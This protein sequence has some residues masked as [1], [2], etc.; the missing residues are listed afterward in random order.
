MTVMLQTLVNQNYH[1]LS[2][3][4]DAKKLKGNESCKIISES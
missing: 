2:I 4:V 3:L 1:N